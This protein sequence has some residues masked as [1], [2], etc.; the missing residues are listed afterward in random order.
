MVSRGGLV[1]R[2]GTGGK[3]TP[4]SSPATSRTST[5]AGVGSVNEELIE[6]GIGENVPGSGVDLFARHAWRYG[7]ASLRLSFNK[8]GVVGKER[9]VRL[10]E[11]VRARGVAAVADGCG[12][13]DVHNDHIPLRQHP[14]GP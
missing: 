4:T 8:Y 3:V 1:V 13:P 14:V 6:L 11:C 12:A 5:P 9:W 10:S 2:D 7:L